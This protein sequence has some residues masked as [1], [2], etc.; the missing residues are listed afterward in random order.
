MEKAQAVELYDS[1]WW[2]DKT[3]LEISLFQLFEPLLCM[4]FDRFHAAVEEA[5]GRPVFTHEFGL[6]WDGLKKEL[7]GERPAPTMEQILEMIPEA[8]R[9]VIVR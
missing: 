7:L 3:A 5:L 1:C 4:P 9:I 8:K 2:V 6:N